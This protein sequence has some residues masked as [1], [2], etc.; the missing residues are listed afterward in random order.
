MFEE[1]DLSLAEPD[2]LAHGISSQET[3]IMSSCESLTNSI[4]KNESLT[5]KRNI[6]PEPPNMIQDLPVQHLYDNE[7]EPE[8]PDFDNETV[9]RVDVQKD[10]SKRRKMDD[11]NITE[12]KRLKFD[13]DESLEEK[14]KIGIVTV[15]D[16]STLLPQRSALEPGKLNFIYATR[17]DSNFLFLLIEKVKSSSKGSSHMSPAPG[18]RL[19]LS[20]NRRTS[21][22]LHPAIKS[23]DYQ[24]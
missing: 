2:L 9:N 10:I 12:A 24:L 21:K 20:R 15:P 1:I 17:C 11:S 14:S 5:I 23:K 8:V 7:L 6:V 3:I 19:G 4:I 18:L 22:P 16:K 13:R